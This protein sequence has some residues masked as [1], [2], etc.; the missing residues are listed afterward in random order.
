L[1][2]CHLACSVDRLTTENH[3]RKAAI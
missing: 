1:H 3:R 2:R